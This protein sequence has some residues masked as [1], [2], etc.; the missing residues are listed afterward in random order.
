MDF[1]LSEDQE[2]LRQG[3]RELL[4]R[5]CDIRR[6]RA[7]AYDGDGRD[8]ELW[9]SLAEA[10]WT[11]VTVPNEDGGAGLRFEDLIVVL[12]EAGRAVLPLPLTTTLLA[13]RTIALE[14]MSAAR[15]DLLSRI[16]SGAAS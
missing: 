14:P 5:A 12:E 8:P 3:L 9:Q 13:A 4:E 7:V 16:T 15:S 11:S 1:E 6:V 2:L 10:G